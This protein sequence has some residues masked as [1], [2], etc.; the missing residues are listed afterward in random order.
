MGAEG[1][2]SEVESGAMDCD[3]YVRSLPAPFE[4]GWPNVWACNSGCGG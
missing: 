4:M 1:V 3:A 2:S